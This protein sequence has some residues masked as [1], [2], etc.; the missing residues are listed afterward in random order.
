MEESFIILD[1]LSECYFNK[2]TY[3]DIYILDK[4]WSLLKSFKI[5]RFSKIGVWVKHFKKMYPISQIRV[6]K[7]L[8]KNN[9]HKP[10]NICLSRLS[11]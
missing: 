8:I 1:E 3:I 5:V 4:E 7:S 6:K 10:P 2:N 11:L 9:L